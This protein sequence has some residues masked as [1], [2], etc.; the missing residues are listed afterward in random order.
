MNRRDVI[1]NTVGA[2]GVAAMAGASGLLESPAFAAGSSS[3]KIAQSASKCIAVGLD[4]L[5]HCQKE[6]AQGNKMMAECA[7]TVA[8]TIAACEALQKL[9]AANSPHLKA[10]AKVCAEICKSC[11]KKCEPHIDHMEVC[12][13]CMN[14]CKEC[15]DACAQA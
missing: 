3:A 1:K 2:I 12:K 15:A 13:A 6:L 10:M 7:A 9:A 8:D 4:C 5:A 14:A 11:A